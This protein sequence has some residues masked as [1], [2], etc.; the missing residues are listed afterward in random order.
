M[1]RS[2][3]IQV[4]I[5]ALLT[6]VIAASAL[7]AAAQRTTRRGLRAITPS[8]SQATADTLW[9]PAD[10]LVTL[11]GYDKPLRA[12]KE[13][14]FVT[15]RTTDTVAGIS[16]T[17]TY[18]DLDGRMLHS[19]TVILPANIPPTHT[20]KVDFPSWDP[21]HT[22]YYLQS[23][24]ARTASHCYPYTVKCAVDY[25]LTAPHQVR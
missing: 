21:Q 6:F 2:T 4:T 5:R 17:I 9:A 25:I 8:T 13:T 23:P 22:F 14:I 24:P 15:N 1:I 11:S 18:L 19:R 20:R 12:T 3:H 10:T 16:L 7:S